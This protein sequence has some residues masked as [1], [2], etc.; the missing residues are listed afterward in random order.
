MRHITRLRI[1]EQPPYRWSAESKEATITEN[2]P[3]DHQWVSIK[4]WVLAWQMFAL[5][6]TTTTRWWP[7]DQ[8]NTTHQQKGL[9]HP[10]FLF[11][12]IFLN[13]STNRSSGQRMIWNN[14]VV[15]RF[16]LGC[17]NAKGVSSNGRAIL[18]LATEQHRS[19][20]YKWLK[21]L[22][23]APKDLLVFQRQMR[24]HIITSYIHIGCFIATFHSE[25]CST[26]STSEP[27][28]H[29][30]LGSITERNPNFVVSRSVV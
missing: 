8:T 14:C 23:I 28:V 22:D 19:R 11:S 13:R 6:I 10:V 1:M 12:A 18:S 26:L 9:Q 5:N 17:A 15:L 4:W 7:Y 30:D 25:W 21:R 3:A 20:T 24:K 16:A 27:A 2:A 29:H